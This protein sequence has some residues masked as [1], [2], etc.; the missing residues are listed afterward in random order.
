[1]SGSA[2]TD[3][4]PV[5]WRY[6]AYSG[7]KSRWRGICCPPPQVP[8]SRSVRREPSENLPSDEQRHHSGSHV[9]PANISDSPIH[10]TRLPFFSSAFSRKGGSFDCHINFFE[11]CD[12][13]A[14][15]ECVNVISVHFLCNSQSA[16]QCCG[17]ARQYCSPVFCCATVDRR[18]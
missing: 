12:K 1:M 6:I 14:L 10:C 18:W 3:H 11:R 16:Q 15:H 13:R 7:P 17:T 9:L 5:T 4:V 2:N 8:R